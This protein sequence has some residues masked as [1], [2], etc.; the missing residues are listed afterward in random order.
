[1]HH[2]YIS[3]DVVSDGKSS[4]VLVV[5]RRKCLETMF[6][7]GECRAESG[8]ARSKSGQCQHQ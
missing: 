6:L 4:A 3:D 7:F 1:M 5:A 8:G 2:E